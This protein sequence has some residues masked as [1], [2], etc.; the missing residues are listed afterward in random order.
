MRLQ[1]LLEKGNTTLTRY[2]GLILDEINPPLDC[3][4]VNSLSDDQ[5]EALFSELP[6]DWDV[7]DLETVLD[8]ETIT[9]SFWKQLD[10]YLNPGGSQ[11]EAEPSSASGDEEENA[12][13]IFSL[14]DQ[15][16]NDYRHYIESFL[17]IR[18]SRVYEFVQ[19]ALN[20]GQLWR[21]PLI[22]LNPAYKRSA[23]T[24][25][26]VQNNLL[27][28]DCQ[29]YFP[30]F[31]FYQHQEEAIRCAQNE[32]PYIL[33]TGTGSGKSLAYIVPIIDDLCRNSNLQGVRAILVYPMNAL[34]N[35]Q[36]QE[37]EKHLHQV[38]H[39]NIRVEQY[40]GQESLTHKTE[41]QNN[42][43]HILL[44]NYV[45][46]E[47][48]LSRKQENKLVSSPK[49]KFVVLD[50]LH[51][52]RGR[53]G[54]DVAIVIRKLRQRCGQD[55]LCIGTSA[56]MSTEGSRQNRQETVAQV[57]SK[58]FGVEVP[59]KNVID[60]TIEPAIGAKA[61]EAD[62]LRR[63]IEAGLPPVS[64]QTKSAFLAH[65]LSAWIERNFGL[66]QEEGE[67]V[68]CT[69]ISLETGATRLAQETGLEE[70][71]CLNTLKAMFLWASRTEALAFRLHQFISQGGSVYATL[72]PHSQRQLTLEGQYRTTR[73]RLLFPL[74]F[75]RECGHDYYQVVYDEYQ[76]EVKPLSAFADI[77]ETEQ[78]GYITLDEPGLWEKEDE[79][80]LPDN[81]FRVT[82]TKGR[83]PKKEFQ[84]F[85]PRQLYI[86]PNGKVE[87]G[88]ISQNASPALTPCWFIPQPFLTCLNCGVV[89][90]KRR[91]EYTKLA[92]LSSEG[93]ST[94]T[95][96]LCLSA[97]TQLQTAS[98]QG[99]VD[100]EATKVLSFTDNR[101]D[102]SLQAGHFNDFVQ[103][104]FL[105]GGLKQAL[106]ENQSLT[107]AELAQEVVKQMG[108]TQ[109]DYARQPAEFGAGKRTNEQTFRRLIE[110]RLY[111]DL[112]R[113]WRIMQPNLEQCGL[114]S[115]VY[116]DLE[117]VCESQELWEREPYHHPILSQATP[118]QR[119]RAIKVL[120]DQLRK[121]LAIDAKFLQPEHL[122]RLQQDTEQVLNES[123]R[124]DSS[125]QLHYAKWAT[126]LPQ[127]QKRW[128]GRLIKL[129]GKS[130]VGRFLRSPR[131]WNWLNETLSEEEYQR[132]IASLIEVLCASGYLYREESAVQLQVSSLVWQNQHLEEIPLDPLNSKRL[133]GSEKTTTPVNAF[134]Q[135]F[136]EQ[137]APA[138][139]SLEGR[140]HTGQVGNELRKEREQAFRDGKLASLFCSPTMELGIDIADLG[141]VHLRNVPPSPANYAQR[142]GRA[143]RGGKPALVITYAS[144]GSGHD[145][146]FFGRPE[147]MVSGVVFPPNLELANQDLIESHLYSLWL[148]YTG[149]NLGSSMNEVLNLE[150]PDYPIKTDLQSQLTLTDAQLDNCAQAAKTILADPFCQQ[151]LQNT[152][153]YSQ[154]WI[155]TKLKNALKEF[156][157]A[158]DRWRRLYQ[159]A[160]EQLNTA[161]QTI[162]RALRG[163][164]TQEEH[165][166]AETLEREARRQLNLL[167]G[168]TSRVQ[169]Q[170]ELEYYPYRYF[171]SEGFLP[172]FNFPRLPIRAYIP[173]GD[174][175]KMISRPRAV[176][177]RELA[178]TNILYYE[179]AKFEVFKT[180]VPVGGIQ[181]DRAAI[182]YQCGYFHSGEQ[183]QR[184]T[185]QNCGHSLDAD[186]Q[187]N[188]AKLNS[189]LPMEMV[190]AR[191]RD[192]VTCDE[193]ERLKYGYQITTHFRYAE[194]REQ[195]AIV[196]NSQQS[197]LNLTYGET[198]E[199]LR[200]NRGLR[201]S[202]E[203]GFKLDATSGQW[204]D[205]KTDIP[206]EH[207]HSE[208]YPIVRDTCNILL[209]EPN[210]L[211]SDNAA[212]YLASLQ[213]VLQRAI[214][215]VYKLEDDELA[216]ERLG[217]GKTLLFWEAAEGGVGVLSQILQDPHAFGRLARTGLELCHFFDHEESDCTQACYQC[218]LSYQNQFD[219]PLLDRYLIKP[220]L[221]QLQAS[222]IT[223]ESA[224]GERKQHYR[225][226]WEQTDPDSELERQVLNAI[227][228]KGMKLP[229]LAQTLIPEANCKPDFLYEESKVAVFCD[230]SVHDTAQQRQQDRIQRDN[231]DFNSPY[232]VFSIRYDQDLSQQLADLASLI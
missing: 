174:R 67:W 141:V 11:I 29:S 128:E 214:Q 42:P 175:S 107:H 82:K 205:P 19:Q 213:A 135:Q 168:Q 129:T 26:L 204:G 105:R 114:L 94:A 163:Q 64:E 203:R 3:T 75:C 8:F 201:Q 207:L 33:T 15:V 40:T 231:L 165:Q 25:D 202:K 162:D 167:I 66:T 68:H 212:G 65:P 157:N 89:H 137:Q 18:D 30:N 20:R 21:D 147:Q 92:R 164:V 126:W 200:I 87:F 106:Q 149:A 100:T 172:G 49:L 47:L 83:V 113:G 37:F 218:L 222:S 36:K 27:H 86:Y 210:H 125:E 188:S 112:R 139:Q 81:W 130:A 76:G 193:E 154:R 17:T 194:G 77:E 223:L 189:L 4:G 184:D 99:T 206:S 220:F 56:T 232:S 132:L 166:N 199:I 63:A 169:T 158:C 228:E 198:A 225:Q 2:V 156:N 192:R 145:Q 226:L 176:A 208:V 120:L 161:R 155:E 97:V 170:T 45:M 182:C 69:P 221:E 57:A 31:R 211:P 181:Y 58:L 43:P 133:Q 5:L 186:E 119:Y 78:A 146:Y 16:V 148:A 6:E 24:E 227:Y 144:L 138:I 185:C 7:A 1:Y 35:S 88:V 10:A 159:D 38:G 209:I 122:E 216:S 152:N 80:R 219:H 23:G 142:S 28:P 197:L 151:D 230:G 217:N 111:E 134:F 46:L 14:R 85:I 48:M 178:P 72:E 196:S 22:Q 140:E 34:I 96:L 73:D 54:A 187:G 179:G 131:A 59:A 55:F 44:T 71:R 150:Q 110:Y 171:A 74:L 191:R 41:I 224:P 195:R 180:K 52:Y 12:F 143:G 108:I 9:D 136:Y 32:E 124:I 103:T 39:S 118:Q 50:E 79:E 13:D 116:R 90:D 123:W 153:W 93:R 104:S 229:D 115:I 177:I 127:N 215:V 95:T 109:E 53:Q 91:S 84:K 101:Q 51:T 117:E 173:Y 102:A 70:Q 121:Q 183:Y 60:E 98:K 61:P 160:L 62:Q 190:I